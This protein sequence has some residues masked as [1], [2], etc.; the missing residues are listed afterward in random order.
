M[1]SNRGLPQVFKDLRQSRCHL[2]VH[3][4]NFLF[5]LLL[6]LKTCVPSSHLMFL[7]LNQFMLHQDPS[8]HNQHLYTVSLLT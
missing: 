2:P 8:L 7:T 3:V 4:V 1:S 6:A 5:I